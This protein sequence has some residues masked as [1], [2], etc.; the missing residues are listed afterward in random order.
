VSSGLTRRETFDTLADAVCRAGRDDERVTLFLQAEASDFLRFNHAAVR[1][2]SHVTQG[3]A[4]LSVSAGGRKAESTLTLTGRRADDIATLQRE[5]SVLQAL[6]ADVPADPYLLW[7]DDIV[8]SG[9]SDTGELPTPGQVIEAV[10]T[11]AAGTDF[12]GFY[13]GGPVVCAFAD[14]KGQRNWHRVE[15]FQIEWCLYHAR[16]KAVKAAYAGTRWSDAEF[17]VRL[18]SSRQRMGL[19]AQ[20][21]VSLAPG[22]YR[23]YLAPAAMV[24]V[25][26]LLAWGGF[27]LKRRRSGTSPLM[28]LAHGDAAL[29]AR[30]QLSEATAL[31]VAPSFTAEGFT[32]PGR[33]P[34]VSAGRS[35]DTLNSP[36][37][38]REF[39]V[40]TN[41]ANAEEMPE[42]LRLEPGALP[43]ADVLPA[44]DTGLYISNLW[45]LNYSDR[46]ACR[47]TGMT[48]FACFKVERGEL[49]APLDVMRF[50]DSFLRLF[51]EGLVALTDEAEQFIATDTYERRQLTSVSTPGVIVDGLNL[52]L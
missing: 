6:L 15:S 47:I 48:R 40:P 34:L 45:Y 52:T 30:V 20:P 18:A 31:G 50:D 2:A 49:V 16:D 1:Q 12:V 3:H 44:L 39:G 19:L 10:G 9:R 5:R 13:A 22:A 28:R 29:D 23:A 11:C 4:T 32:R 17:A 33:V 37:S 27:G 21:P 25:L 36:R 7:P 24:E 38:A 43:A 51:G 26:E 14:S 42:S 8:S 46:Q 35:A 41:G